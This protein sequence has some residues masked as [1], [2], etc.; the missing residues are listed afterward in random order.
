[1]HR[2]V[3]RKRGGADTDTVDPSDLP[4]E[5]RPGTV[6]RFEPDAGKVADVFTTKRVR[7]P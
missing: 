7:D 1:V 3:G 4:P 5:S 2:H 6:A